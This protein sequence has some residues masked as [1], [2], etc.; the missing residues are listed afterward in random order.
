MQGD[1]VVMK[2]IVK[3]K[4]LVPVVLIALLFCFQIMRDNI[5]FTAANS[6]YSADPEG[7]KI[8]YLLLRKIGYPVSAWR[9][10]LSSLEG[11]NK[12]LLTF[13]PSSPFSDRECNHIE[14]WVRKGG[15]LLVAD[16]NPNAIYRHFGMIVYNGGIERPRDVPV[17]L[18]LRGGGAKSITITSGRRIKFRG[19]SDVEHLIFDELGT[20]MARCTF[21]NG[22]ITVTSAPEIFSN[23]GLLKGD[24]ALVVVNIPSLTGGRK[25]LHLDEYHHGLS[26]GRSQVELFSLPLKLFLLQLLLI[27]ILYLFSRSIRFR[28]YVP[29]PSAEK[30]ESRE[31]ISVMA[32]LLQRAGAR[33][34]ALSILFDEL[35]RKIIVRGGLPS[36]TELPILA[37]SLSEEKKC[38]YE[39]ALQFLESCDKTIQGGNLDEKTLITTAQK[40]D[41]LGKEEAYGIR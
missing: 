29:L 13:S 16:A 24:N 36:G 6:I 20:V 8:Y 17:T 28:R 7:G 5:D 18:A 40:I 37:R 10:P 26:R 32:R 11:Q 2:G 25:S 3:W 21:G 15:E 34:G 27:S 12:A 23:R 1:A 30:R 31:F 22:H 39:E 41:E 33:K 4:L 19:S 14:Q 35:R 9:R 38:G